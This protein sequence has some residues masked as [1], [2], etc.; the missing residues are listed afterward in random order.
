MAYLCV[1]LFLD[2]CAS[3]PTTEISC[4]TIIQ[5][6]QSKGFFFKYSRCIKL[7]PKFFCRLFLFAVMKSTLV[8]RA[9]LQYIHV[10]AYHQSQIHTISKPDHGRNCSSSDFNVFSSADAHVAV[11][12]GILYKCGPGHS[13]FA[14]VRF[15]A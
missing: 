9:V 10:V 8:L 3:R 6:A 13:D 5:V 14:F 15:C 11:Q 4:N 1:L 7:V 12:H 2:E